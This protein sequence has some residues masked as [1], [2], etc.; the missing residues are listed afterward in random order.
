MHWNHQ[1]I[2]FFYFHSTRTVQALASVW[3]ERFENGSSLILHDYDES[4]PS[5]LHESTNGVPINYNEEPYQTK[6]FCWP[7]DNCTYHVILSWCGRY[8]HLMTSG[9]AYRSIFLEFVPWSEAA[10]HRFS[11]KITVVREAVSI[12]LKKS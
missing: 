6:Q 3:L 8:L 5:I 2:S 12:S 1:N 9:A 4:N 11:S 10:D 7:G